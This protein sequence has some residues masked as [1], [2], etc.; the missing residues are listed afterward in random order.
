[1]AEISLHRALS[2]RKT[3]KAR[4]E[5]EI[6]NGRFIAIK[7]GENGDVSGESPESVEKDIR[8]RYD[9]IESLIKN[10][11]SLNSAITAANAGIT[12][13]TTGI[14]KVKL[15]YGNRTVTLADIIQ[16]KESVKYRRTFLKVL[17][18]QMTDAIMTVE[19][20][21]AETN[22]RCDMLISSMK[23]GNDKATV[24]QKEIDSLTDSFHKNNDYK[25]VDP[26]SLK[27][28]IK[29]TKDELDKADVEIDSKNSELNAL[30]KIEIDF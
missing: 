12:K 26:L 15:D 22:N 28:L 25:L 17:T 30:T 21:M 7:V 16:L 19:R 27:K 23:N 4:I 10:L 2:L 29:E 24:N 9:K 5:E 20:S 3:T 13:D 1:M 8:G 11:E 14:E 18:R 6:A